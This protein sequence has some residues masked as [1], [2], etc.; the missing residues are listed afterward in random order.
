MKTTLL[1]YFLSTYSLT[2]WAFFGMNHIRIHFGSD[3]RDA[4]NELYKEGW[5]RKRPGANVDIIE[6]IKFE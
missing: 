6:L 1:N 2:G 5:I 3:I 4:L